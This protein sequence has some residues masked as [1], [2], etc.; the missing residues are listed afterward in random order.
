VL[1]QVGTPEEVYERPANRFV[2]GFIGSP[3]MQFADAAAVR[4]AGVDVPE[5]AIVGVR[6][7]AARPWPGEGLAGPLRGT[8]AYI[9]ALGRETVVGVDAEGARLAVL[10]EGRSA[11]QPGETLEF[12]LVPGALRC[13]DA[14]TGAALAHGAG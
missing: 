3:A 14:A 9:E 2:G 6:P 4:A 7:E 5:G 1:E 12:G 11:L 8:V 10:V 13:F